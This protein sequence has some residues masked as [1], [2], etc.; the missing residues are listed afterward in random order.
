MS[1]HDFSVP[2]SKI[3]EIKNETQKAG[4]VHTK[5]GIPKGN[6]EDKKDY[7]FHVAAAEVVRQGA[8]SSAQCYSPYCQ[9]MVEALYQLLQRLKQ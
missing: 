9:P 1:G 5:I 6:K 7:N 4:R 3:Y 8:T 2:Y